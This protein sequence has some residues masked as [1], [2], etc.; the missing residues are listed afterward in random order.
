MILITLLCFLLGW[1]SRKNVSGGFS[2]PHRL[3]GRCCASHLL[4]P[5]HRLR[6]RSSTSA[7]TRHGSAESALAQPHPDPSPPP[8]VPEAVTAAPR[9][10]LSGAAPR[11]PTPG[12]N[13]SR[14]ARGGEARSA[15]RPGP[16]HPAPV[17]RQ[18]GSLPRSLTHQIRSCPA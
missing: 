18:P 9:T 16:A 17:T 8:A 10:G 2:Q 13:P 5:F 15:A 11:D 12:L 1:Q 14:G 6:S 4:P 7:M 3:C